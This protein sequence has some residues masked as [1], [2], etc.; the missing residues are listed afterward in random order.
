MIM[1]FYAFFCILVLLFTLN[2]CDFQLRGYQQ[3]LPFHTLNVESNP[4]YTDFSKELRQTLEDIG[5]KTHLACPAPLTLR[6]LSQDFTRTITSLG[7]AGQTTTY[8]LAF[9]VLFQLVD[10]ADH[11]LLS[12]EQIRVTRNFS[13]TTTQLGGD[14]NTQ[15][16]LE[17][18]MRRDA[19]Q[20]LIT[21]LTSPALR[22][23]ISQWCTSG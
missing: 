18:D 5:V 3:T 8:L 7:N 2:G 9:T 22:Q 17:A 13:I 23:Q 10:H 1:R 11:V 21:R 20:Q 19:I 6:I 4:L 14:L 15:T 16:D 12:G